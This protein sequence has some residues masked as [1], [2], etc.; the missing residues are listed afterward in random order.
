MCVSLRPL[1]AS[2]LGAKRKNFTCSSVFKRTWVISH[3]K[4]RLVL[5]ATSQDLAHWNVATGSAKAPVQVLPTRLQET[6]NKVRHFLMK[7]DAGLR[8]IRDKDCK[9]MGTSN[10]L[11]DFVAPDKSMEKACCE[12]VNKWRGPGVRRSSGCSAMWR[13]HTLPPGSSRRHESKVLDTGRELGGELG[14]HGVG[15]IPTHRHPLPCRVRL[16]HLPRRPR[17]SRH[18]KDKAAGMH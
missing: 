15:I 11:V 8:D 10:N 4:Q 1:T 9:D 6:R 5:V 16:L 3:T 14:L 7:S 17:A 2:L 12:V 13:V 18:S